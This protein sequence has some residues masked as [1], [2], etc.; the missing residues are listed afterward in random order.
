[1]SATARCPQKNYGTPGTK[2]PNK[3]MAV[4]LL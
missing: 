3:N 4:A 2:R 1:M